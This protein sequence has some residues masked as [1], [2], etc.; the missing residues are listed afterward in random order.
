LTFYLE[1]IFA[2]YIPLNINVAITNKSKLKQKLE[3]LW[4]VFDRAVCYFGHLLWPC[5]L[6][7]GHSGH[8]PG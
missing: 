6:E 3:I 7:L 5:G 8:F 2:A 4:A 1:V